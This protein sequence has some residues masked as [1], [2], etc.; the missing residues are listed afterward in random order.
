M[1]PLL[2][3]P[4]VGGLGA[5]APAALGFGADPDS[6]DFSSLAGAACSGSA[7]SAGAGFA[8][9]GFAALGEAGFSAVLDLGAASLAAAF[10]KASL[11]LFAT[12]GAMVD[13]P[14]FTYSPSSSNLA[15]ATLVSI[16]SSLAT[17]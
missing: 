3:T 4:E 2:G 12:G 5:E 10:G 8:G 11:S 16:P 6:A 1:F 14:L 15:K 13:D 7:G 9:P 17:S